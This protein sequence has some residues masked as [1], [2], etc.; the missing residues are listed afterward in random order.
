[1]NFKLD[2][3][4]WKNRKRE[5]LQWK[6]RHKERQWKEQIKQWLFWPGVFLTGF[7]FYMLNV[8]AGWLIGSLL[9]G[10]VYR[11]TVAPRQADSRLFSV[12][13]CLIGL[14]LG[15]MLEVGL[16]WEAVLRF[17]WAMMVGLI[18]TVG[19]SLLLGHIFFRVSGLDRKTALF[20]FMP[21]GASEVL[22]LADREGADVRIVAAFHT[23]R[24]VLFVTMIPLL[25]GAGTGRAA[26]RGFFLRLVEAH[27]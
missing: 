14:T 16:L 1:M 2:F 9:A 6:K 19:G 5:E 25:A 12:A 18:L 26:S 21:G 8:P 27:E 20:S 10:M 3:R 4:Q 11:F 23:A 7:V 24:I 17:G 22:G 13:L 15:A